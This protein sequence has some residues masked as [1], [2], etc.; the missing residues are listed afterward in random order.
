MHIMSTNPES[1]A[2]DIR[3]SPPRL[4]WFETWA[5]AMADFEPGHVHA[6]ATWLVDRP[7][8]LTRDF[9]SDVVDATNANA[10]RTSGQRDG[11][12]PA[13]AFWIVRGSEDTPAVL[14]F[15]QIRHE[16]NDFLFNSGGHVGVSVR[17]AERRT[18]VARRAFDLAVDHARSVGITRLLVTCDESNTASRAAIESVGAQYDDS[19]GGT[20]RYWLDLPAHSPFDVG[21]GF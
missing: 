8:E 1:S 13:D 15:V 3:L 11:L 12:V 4:D 17:R 7:V 14:G 6:A 5:N 9:L 2:S 19:R 21:P 16:L 20:R 10:D 18:G